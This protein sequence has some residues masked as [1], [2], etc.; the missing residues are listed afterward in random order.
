[1]NNL[2]LLMTFARFGALAFGGGYMTIPLLYETFVQQNAVFSPEQFGNLMS[3][4]QM[5]PGPTSINVA[6]YVGYLE[7]GVF[8]AIAASIGLVC[9]SLCLTTIALFFLNKY[10]NSWFIQGYLRGARWIAFVM[11]L[12]AATL[13]LN[14]SVFSESWPISDMIASLRTRTLIMPEDFR[15]NGLETLIATG[16]FILARRQVRVTYIL[17]G[18][19]LLG[20]ALSFLSFFS[21]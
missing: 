13:F 18:S 16:S 12:Y 17:L 2:W 15:L 10:Q 1:M 9:P 11:V 4:S 7:S 3:I 20:Y 14:I 19:A 6:T 8:G 5:T 21:E